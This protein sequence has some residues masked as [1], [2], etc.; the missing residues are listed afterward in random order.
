MK[1]ASMKRQSMML[2]GALGL[3]LSANAKPIPIDDFAKEPN[4]SSL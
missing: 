3:V 4:I 2:A 1:G